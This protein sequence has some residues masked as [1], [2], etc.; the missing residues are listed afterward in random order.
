MVL[1][2][3]ILL[4]DDHKVVCKG[5][6]ALLEVEQDFQVVGEANDGLEALRLVEKLHPDVLLLDLMM[7][8]LNGLEVARQVSQHLSSTHIIVLS[9]HSNEAYVLEALR[10]GAIG[11]VLKQSNEEDLVMGIRQ[12]A[13]GQRYLSPPLT[14]RAI[15]SYFE[16]ARTTTVQDPYDELTDREREVFQLAAEGYSNSEIGLRLSIS[17]RTVETH[18]QNLMDKLGLHSQTE[19]VRYA[20]K[21]GFIE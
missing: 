8:G 3:T 18:R 14:E 21:R 2:I 17:P 12:V 6:R 9:M 19:L 5:L 11:Y 10:N 15:E 13:S 16:K 4:A 20:L 1:M 7:P